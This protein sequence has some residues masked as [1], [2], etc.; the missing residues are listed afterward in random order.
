MGERR[1]VHSGAV[2]LGEEV[3]RGC[4]GM[5]ACRPASEHAGD[6][7]VK[8]CATQQGIEAVAAARGVGAPAEAAHHGIANDARVP[9]AGLSTSQHES[10]RF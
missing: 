1:V 5:P 7:R 2:R 8:L 6:A 9:C 10:H 3:N 4:A